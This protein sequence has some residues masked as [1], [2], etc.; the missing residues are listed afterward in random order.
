MN[1][2]DRLDIYQKNPPAF[3]SPFLSAKERQRL[4]GVNRHCGREYTSFPMFK[5]LSHYSRF[6]HSVGVSLLLSRFT[7][8][9]KI[10]L[11]GLFHDIA[12]PAFAHVI[13]FLLGDH[14]KQEATESKTEHF[15]NNSPIIQT[16]LQNLGLSTKDVSNYHLYPLADNDSPRLSADRLEYTLSN[17]LN[18][19][20]GSKDDILKILNDLVILK[21]EDNL[22]ERGFRTENT[23]YLRS[24]LSLKCGEIYTMD[25]D[26]YG[27]EYLAHVIKKAINN[28]VLSFDDLYT[29]EDRVIQKLM[30]NPSTKNSFISFTSLSKV[31]RCKEGNPFSYKINAKKRFIDPLIQ[32]KGRASFVFPDLKKERDAFKSLS[33]DYYLKGN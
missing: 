25:E 22:V 29:S 21:S 27:R 26:R 2:K 23:A 24:E 11:S 28:R 17:T 9:P 1:I 3:L 31:T 13:D 19:G 33:F 8:D 32:N 6:N 16:G 5:D 4:K 30:D 10:I 15:I 14:L 12:T 18:F 20:L 7:T